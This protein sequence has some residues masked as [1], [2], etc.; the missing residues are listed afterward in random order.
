MST[1]SYDI[2]GLALRGQDYV[3]LANRLISILNRFD[4][5]MQTEMNK[6]IAG[7]ARIDIMKEYEKARREMEKYPGKIAE[8]GTALINV[9]ETG[10]AVDNSLTGQV[11]LSLL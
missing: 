4:L 11:N 8:V 5:I 6:G 7:D 1:I 2:K 9:S 3:S 10:K